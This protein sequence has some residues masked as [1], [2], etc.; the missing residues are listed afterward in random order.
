MFKT[1]DP[2]SNCSKIVSVLFLKTHVL[3]EK[4]KIVGQSVT[5]LMQLMQSG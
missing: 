1:A 5:K 2:F 4:S 3:R